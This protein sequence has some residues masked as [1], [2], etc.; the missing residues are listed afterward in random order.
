MMTQKKY[1]LQEIVQKYINAYININSFDVINPA[2]NEKITSVPSL[3]SEH[4]QDAIT[5]A[6]NSYT[7]FWKGTLSQKRS[8]YLL[9]WANTLEKEVDQLALLL[10]IE[11]GKTLSEAHAELQWAIDSV[12]NYA[13]E[14]RRICG[15]ILPYPGD[16]RESFVIKEPFGV[17]GSITPWN[18][19][20][21][22]SI[23]TIAAA[24]ASGNTI[25][26]KPAE[27]TPLTVIAAA[28]LAYNSG[29]PTGVI[30]VLT[31]QTPSV[32]GDILCND[33][34]FFY[35]VYSD[36]KKTIRKL[37]IYSKKY[38]LRIRW[39]LSFYYI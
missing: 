39:K 20:A 32:A 30:Q 33:T 2:T 31:T 4:I 25:V 34:R 21:G 9:N 17:I 13:Y 27:D 19:P 6:S 18:F 28:M 3:K 12:R 14:A 22:I 26:I 36:R 11:Q 38:S 8:N 5:T 37:L 29:L 15:Q 23:N 35:R 10:T 1:P 24:L 7:S 16:N